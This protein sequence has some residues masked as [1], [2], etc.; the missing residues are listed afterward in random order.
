MMDED[1][2]PSSSTKAKLGLPSAPD[3]LELNTAINDYLADDN[4]RTLPPEFLSSN[5]PHCMTVVEEAKKSILKNLVKAYCINVQLAC[6]LA[7]H[8]GNYTR[9]ESIGNVEQMIER[10][11]EVYSDFVK[12]TPVKSLVVNQFFKAVFGW[13]LDF[14]EPATNVRTMMGYSRDISDPIGATQSIPNVYYV[15]FCD[16]QW[17]IRCLELDIVLRAAKEQTNIFPVLPKKVGTQMDLMT[18]TNTE[19]G[20]VIGSSWSTIRQIVKLFCS[21]NVERIAPHYALDQIEFAGNSFNLYMR[22]RLLALTR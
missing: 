17:A 7:T 21:D 8:Q 11:N 19:N 13:N 10:T 9:S 1:D 18:S 6:V 2:S 20:H 16:L 15:R 3:C 14:E 12:A 5:T 4:C 22:G